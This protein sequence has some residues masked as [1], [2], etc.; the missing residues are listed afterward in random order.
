MKYD[1]TKFKFIDLFNNSDGK[2]SGSG[3]AG[4]F[5]FFVG[6]VIFIAAA[7]GYFLQLPLMNELMN[8]IIVLISASA[9]L[10]GVRKIW[11]NTP[12]KEEGMDV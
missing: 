3:V 12:P 9:A 10:L 7:I 8:H 1:G 2:T 5:G 6:L 11:G 4:L